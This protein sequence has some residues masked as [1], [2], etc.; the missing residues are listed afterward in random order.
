MTF[1][2]KQ[3]RAA[4]KKS[5]LNKY[6]IRFTMSIF[7]IKDNN[8]RVTFLYRNEEYTFGGDDRTKVMIAAFKKLSRLVDENL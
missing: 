2:S 4:G 8:H 6:G 1:T 5:A 7:P 3:A